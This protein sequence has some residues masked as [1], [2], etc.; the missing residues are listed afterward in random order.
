MMII[1]I[2]IVIVIV[3][4]IVVVFVIIIIIIVVVVVVVINIIFIIIVV[5]IVAIIIIIIII[6]IFINGIN[7]IIIMNYKLVT[8]QSYFFLIEP[9]KKK[10]KPRVLHQ[11]ICLLRRLRISVKLRERRPVWN[12]WIKQLNPRL[13][14]L[15]PKQSPPV[16]RI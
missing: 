16:G 11:S 9:R 10:A 8:I 5:G 7:V 4:I 15:L 14:L 1:I 2:V 13:P 6:I 3:I 12:G